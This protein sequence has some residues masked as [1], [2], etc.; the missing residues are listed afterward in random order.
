MKLLSGDRVVSVAKIKN[1]N[2]DIEDV[3]DVDEE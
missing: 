1:E 3:E 2:A